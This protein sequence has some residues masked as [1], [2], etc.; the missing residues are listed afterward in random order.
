MQFGFWKAARELYENFLPHP[1][2]EFKY[3]PSKC[4]LHAQTN[5]HERGLLVPKISV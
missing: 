5:G 3:L 1:E 2:A 4:R